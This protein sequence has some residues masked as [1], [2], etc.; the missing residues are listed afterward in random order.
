MG[1]GGYVAGPVGAR[2]RAAAAPAR[3]DR[4]RQP[5]G[6]LQPRCSRRFA[7]ARLPR[8]SRSTG[9]DGE[10]YLVTGRPVPPPATDRAA[11]RARFGL[12]DGRALRARLRRLAR[13]RAR[14]TRRRVEAFAAPTAAGCRGRS[15]P[16]ARATSPSLQP[17]PAAALRPA[18]VHRRLRRGAAGRATSSSRAPAARSSR[19]R[20]TGAGDPDPV[21]ARRAPTTRRANARWMERAAAR[22]SSSPTAS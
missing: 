14:S 16:P 22:R 12:G 2:R 17:R 6:P 19:S 15:T 11:A 13:A 5:P 3:A 4:G 1:G 10:R 9:R 18:R 8:R 21:P 20:P 7:R